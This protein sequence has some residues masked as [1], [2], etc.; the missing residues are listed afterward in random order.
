VRADRL[1]A[2]LL[3]LQSRGQVTAAEVADELEISERTARRDLEALGIAGL[4]VYSQQG[5][6]GG[7]RL[8]GG[9]RTDLSGL[10]AAEVRALFLT[11]GAAH[12]A[13][14]GTAVRGA[15][16]KLM[17]ALP[18]GFRAD[19]EAAANAIVIDRG[20]WDAAPVARS[21]PEH[22]DAV[23]DAVVSSR[24][25]RIGYVDRAGAATERVVSPLGLV[26]KRDVWYLV[27]D[28]AA[29]RRTFRVDR[30]ESV[31]IT[32]ERVERPAGF[33]LA[34]VWRQVV[35]EVEER[36]TPVR[37]HGRIHAHL[38]GHLRAT[39]GPRAQIGPSDGEW[40]DV[41]LR[42][43]HLVALAAEVAGFGAGLEITD[44][45]ELRRELARIGAELQTV[46]ASGCQTPQCGV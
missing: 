2:I 30:I 20:G 27:A 44:P 24:E 45:D 3:M 38:L 42:G 18:E 19:A 8:V 22:L 13:A 33:D 25:L 41:E 28:T 12:G 43:H 10:T 29:G 11:V 26:T 9:G 21:L 39:L 35:D 31:E 17:R 46:Y 1:V 7:W 16:R 36:R 14:S 6:G 32:G 37:A 5:R 15:L 4:P 34:E 23:Q 40:V